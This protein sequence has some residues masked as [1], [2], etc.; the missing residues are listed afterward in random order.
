MIKIDFRYALQ[1]MTCDGEILGE[2]KQSLNERIVEKSNPNG[3]VSRS[4]NQKDLYQNIKKNL[5]ER[6]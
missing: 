3:N 6:L 1:K 4:N 5:R 2:F